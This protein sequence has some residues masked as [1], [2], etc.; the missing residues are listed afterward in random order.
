[1]QFNLIPFGLWYLLNL[2]FV[3]KLKNELSLCTSFKS[4]LVGGFE[5]SLQ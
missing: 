1:M 5:C 3:A 4:K 2:E